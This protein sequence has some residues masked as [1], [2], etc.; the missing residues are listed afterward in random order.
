MRGSASVEGIYIDYS[1]CCTRK[2]AMTVPKNLGMLLLAVWLILF[3]LLTSPFLGFSFSH[4]GDVLGTLAIVAGVL[5][6][7]Q[8]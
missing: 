2:L 8:R 4:S 5:L 3:G 6:L 7:M 1:L